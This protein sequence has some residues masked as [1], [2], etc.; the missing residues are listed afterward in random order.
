MAKQVI[1]LRKDLNMRKGKMIAQGAHASLGVILN[2]MRVNKKTY[3]LEFGN[4]SYLDEWLNGRFTKI[5]VGVNSEIDLINLYE[6]AMEKDIPCS[7]IV[8]AGLT[9]FNGVKTRTAVA[10]GPYYDD[11]IDE[12]TGNLELL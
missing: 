1:V 12:I 2:L 6:K 9:E 10:I 11:K 7:I 3:K 4:G 5:V 8:D